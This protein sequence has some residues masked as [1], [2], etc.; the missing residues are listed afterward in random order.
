MVVVPNP[1]FFLRFIANKKK[2]LIFAFK[3]AKDYVYFFFSE[4][5]PPY[6]FAKVPMATRNKKK[7]TVLLIASIDI[8]TLRCKYYKLLSYR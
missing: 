7:S 2:K 8:D 6:L 1:C 3:K 5:V 4:A